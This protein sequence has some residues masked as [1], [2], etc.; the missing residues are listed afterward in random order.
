MTSNLPNSPNY[1]QLDENASENKTTKVQFTLFLILTVILGTETFITA[2]LLYD[3]SE[4][5]HRVSELF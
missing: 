2:F 5:I 3:F 1:S 4:D